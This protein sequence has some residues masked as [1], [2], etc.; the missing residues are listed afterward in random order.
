MTNSKRKI[1]SAEE[2]QRAVELV[3]A[4]D[5]S[6]AE[7]AAAYGCT[8]RAVQQWVKKSERGTNLD[9]LVT[10]PNPGAPAKLSP[11]QQQHLLKLLETGAQAAG[12]ESQLWNGPRIAK[13]IEDT[14]QVTYNT[15]Y[16]PALL[17]S[18]G[19]SVQKPKRHAVERDEEKIQ[20]W[21]D[22]DWPR[23]KKSETPAGDTGLLG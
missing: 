2:R 1:F 11:D 16:I 10:P 6:P 9:A 17:R 12:F 18:L 14:F 19:W 13:L 7:V 8:P 5:W 3:C 23:L 20:E 21:I 22:T 15:R 4:H